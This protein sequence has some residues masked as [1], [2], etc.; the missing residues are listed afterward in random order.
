MYSTSFCP[1]RHSFCWSYKL[2]QRVRAHR[3][4]ELACT[5]ATRC[6]WA[7]MVCRSSYNMWVLCYWWGYTQTCTRIYRGGIGS[8]GGLRRRQR[9][10]WLRTASVVKGCVCCAGLVRWCGDGWDD[11]AVLHC[12]AW[13]RDRGTM[14]MMMMAMLMWRLRR[15]HNVSFYYVKH[16][17]WDTRERLRHIFTTDAQLYILVHHTSIVNV[18]CKARSPPRAGHSTRHK[19]IYCI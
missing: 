15:P 1:A 2:S 11:C 13:H 8:D 3:T 16:M 12:R 10:R 17:R 18:C 5:L 19:S 6:P 9:R 4:L 14:L 7:M